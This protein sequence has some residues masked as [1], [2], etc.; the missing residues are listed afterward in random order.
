MNHIQP[1]A[2]DIGKNPAGHPEWTGAFEFRF[3][4]FQVGD[5]GR[6][7]NVP[8]Y[9]D[10]A[11]W[12]R[13]DTVL[14]GLVLRDTGDRDCLDLRAASVRG[15]SHRFGAKVRQDS[16]AYR[17]DGR[18]TVAAV[19]DGV[20][21]GDLSHLAADLAV[22]AG[23][24]FVTQQ[25]TDRV[26]YELDWSVVLQV[27]SKRIVLHGRRVLQDDQSPGRQI[28]KRMST[29]ILFAVVD[30]AAIQDCR[31]VYTVAFGDSSAWL[32]RG[33]QTWE[34]QRPVK[35]ADTWIASSATDAL[36]FFTGEH[37]IE[38]VRTVLGPDDTLVLMSDGVGDPLGDGAGSVGAFLAEQWRRP[39][40]QLAFAAHVD[41]ARRSH[42]DDRTALAI[43][44][45]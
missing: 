5:P 14:D 22:R 4:Q 41:F 19:A 20:S 7:A 34:P 33:G 28:G 1:S 38:P 21:D 40:P 45:R 32:L 9:P 35:N 3:A 36:P 10:P 15:R 29:T 8:G 26:P 17:C 16:Y 25:L 13:P 18:Y 11:D 31:T 27:I 44:P 6:A 30:M 23:C 39:P 12:D 24:H 43:W 2:M 42:D 37:P